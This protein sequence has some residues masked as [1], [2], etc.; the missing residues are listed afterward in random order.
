L[1]DEGTR[2]GPFPGNEL[3]TIAVLRFRVRDFVQSSI[4]IFPVEELGSG[5]DVLT[6]GKPICEKAGHKF[7]HG[8][9]VSGCKLSS[10]YCL[11]KLAEFVARVLQKRPQPEVNVCLSADEAEC[12]DDGIDGALRNLQA[13]G[14]TISDR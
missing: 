9:V 7:F 10:L 6:A 1:S 4:E 2:A 14:L 3:Q 5:L 8:H 12:A 13:F 11:Q